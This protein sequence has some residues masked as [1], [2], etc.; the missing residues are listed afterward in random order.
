MERIRRNHIWA[1]GNFP[2]FPL[3]GW[4]QQLEGRTA[5]FGDLGE[6][7]LVRDHIGGRFTNVLC[8][9][10][11]NKILNIQ[12]RGRCAGVL[13]KLQ[14]FI[15]T[16]DRYLIMSFTKFE[17]SK[18]TFN[19]QYLRFQYLGRGE[20]QSLLS[21]WHCMVVSFRFCA[22]WKSQSSWLDL[23]IEGFPPYDRQKT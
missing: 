2:H 16:D 14:K 1:V 6:A 21:S 8:E 12:I 5:N 22:S 11:R 19:N 18:L 15:M 7:G 3:Q 20:S 4:W 23:W 17:R 10:L 13:H 9:H